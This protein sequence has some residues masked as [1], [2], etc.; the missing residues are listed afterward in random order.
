MYTRYATILAIMWFIL[1]IRIAASEPIE[2][3]ILAHIN[4]L[5]WTDVLSVYYLDCLKTRIQALQI[6]SCY[7]PSLQKLAKKLQGDIEEHI[8]FCVQS[9]KAT[10]RMQN[11]TT[12]HSQAHTL[13]AS[14]ESTYK[15]LSEVQDPFDKALENIESL[16]EEKKLTNILQTKQLKEAEINDYKNCWQKFCNTLD[17]I[18]QNPLTK[19]KPI[20]LADYKS[21]ITRNIREAE[22]IYPTYS[23]LF[24][25]KKDEITKNMENIWGHNNIVKQIIHTAQDS[26]SGLMRGKNILHKTEIEGVLASLSEKI[27]NRTKVEAL[28]SDVQKFELPAW[29]E[30][31]ISTKHKLLL[32]KQAIFGETI[33][34]RLTL[35]DKDIYERFLEPLKRSLDATTLCSTQEYRRLQET[36][37]F[38]QQ[39]AQEV[40]KLQKLCMDF[41]NGSSTQ[42][43]TFLKSF[44]EQKLQ[45]MQSIVTHAW[46]SLDELI[47]TEKTV[48]YSI[49]TL[50]YLKEKF[51]HCCK[52]LTDETSNIQE[53]LAAKDLNVYYLTKTYLSDKIFIPMCL[54]NDAYIEFFVDYFHKKYPTKKA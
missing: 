4:D 5:I 38:V 51:N 7:Y 37:R 11:L 36:F 42:S 24:S 29:P 45:G 16:I 12:R 39:S 15:K 32:L 30:K 25:F 6:T 18:W 53:K 40:E 33:R 14:L 46:D 17:A 22:K 49:A 19:N 27:T 47:K 31:W 44:I 3:E 50:P 28:K 34:D 48:I 52:K 9:E 2:S 41:A 21:K 20:Q 26:I 43:D 23:Y 13:L 54:L 35:V 1:P 8:I 10:D